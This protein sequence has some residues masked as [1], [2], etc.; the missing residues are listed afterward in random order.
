MGTYLDPPKYVESWP[1]GP[2]LGDLGHYSTY[3]GGLGKA[4]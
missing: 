3:F 2:Y 1:F 4:Q